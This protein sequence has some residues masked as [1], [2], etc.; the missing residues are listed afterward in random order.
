MNHTAYCK[1]LLNVTCPYY[2]HALMSQQFQ[3]EVIRMRQIRHANILPVLSSFVVNT[4]IC[5]VTPLMK[6]GS[7]RDLLDT[8]FPE[9]NELIF[10]LKIIC[11][12]IV[13]LTCIRNL[14]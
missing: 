5:I 2:I 1:T 10:Q 3:L 4:D 6:M 7:A 12:D 9:G 11:F 8:H 14:P 13:Y